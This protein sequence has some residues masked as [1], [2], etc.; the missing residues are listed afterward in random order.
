LD[1]ELYWGMRHLA[2]VRDYIPR[3]VGA[4][5]AIPAL[6]RLFTEYSIHATWATVGFLFFDQTSS[7]LEFAPRQRPQYRKRV[8][9]PYSDL[10]P[11]E[12]RETTDSIFFAPSLIRLIADTANQEVGTHTFSH[13]F[14]LEEGQD[15]EA[16]RHDLLAA[17]RAAQQFGLQ[18]RSLVFPQNEFKAQYIRPCLEAGITAYRG[19]PPSWIYRETAQEQQGQV[20]RLGRLMD[21]YLPIT[22]GN[23][24][25]FTP[26]IEIAPVNVPA[27]R[28]LRPYSRSLRGFDPMR[29]RRIACE[30]T[31]A[32]RKGLLY[33]LWWHPHNFG[34]DTEHNLA[35]LRRVLDHYRSLQEQYGFESRNMGEVAEDSCLAAQ[36]NGRTPLVESVAAV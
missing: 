7:L 6:L 14:C 29:L 32:A 17:R 21:A 25:T 9:Y 30:M 26:S 8:L 23:C 33:H 2:S 15:I 28:F 31:M 24:H 16:F 1:F 27:S 36:P 35:F 34:L 20:R 3:L 4:R 13:Y 5:A 18:L 10:P 11:D 22:S 19:N 12:V